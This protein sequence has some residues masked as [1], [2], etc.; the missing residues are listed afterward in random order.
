M[1]KE[2][3]A[4]ISMTCLFAGMTVFAAEYDIAGNYVTGIEDNTYKMIL[5]T[6]GNEISNADDIVYIGQS[7]GEGAF[8]SAMKF[9]LKENPTEGLYSVFLGGREGA[10][11]KDSLTF[12]IGSAQQYGSSQYAKRWTENN[13]VAFAWEDIDEISDYRSVI[14]QTEEKAFAIELSDMEN[15]IGSV[16]LG[17]RITGVPDDT[18]IVNAYLSTYGFGINDTEGTE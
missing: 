8:E 18:E 15:Y 5:I 17:V 14:I 3:S 16:S 1:K 11:D 7:S 10:T 4:L 12:Y 6:K 2:I 13:S 9:Y